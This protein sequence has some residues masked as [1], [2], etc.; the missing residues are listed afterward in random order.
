M[1]CWVKPIS[2]KSLCDC[3]AHQPISRYPHRLTADSPILLIPV[4]PLRPVIYF[5][6][7]EA[8]RL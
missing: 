5:E 1:G 7:L 2:Q 3:T 8:G 6:E 4:N